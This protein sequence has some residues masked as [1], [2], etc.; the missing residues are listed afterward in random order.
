MVETSGTK[1][2]GVPTEEQNCFK[3]IK[4]HFKKQFL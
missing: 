3:T 1:Q 2:S 4:D